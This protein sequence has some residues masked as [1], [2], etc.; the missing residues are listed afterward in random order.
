MALHTS[1]APLGIISTMSV[2]IVTDSGS[3][4]T[5]EL[6]ASL[7]VTVVPLRVLLGGKEYRDGVDLTPDAFY[8]KLR[9]VKELPKTSQPTPHDLEAAYRAAAQRGP[10]VG[11]HLSSALS[12]T[13]QGAAM[14]VRS[15]DP[16][17][18]LVDSRSGSGGE[19]LLVLEAV[20]LSR[21]GAGPDEIVERV[22]RMRLK[23]ETLV[24]LNT[25]ENAV[26]GG[27]VSPIA[28][29]AATLLGI[30][31]IV[32]VTDDGRV[33]PLD[34]VRGRGRALQRLLDLAAERRTDWRD[35]RVCVAHGG[36]EPDAR[37]FADQVRERFDPREVTILPIGATIGTYSAEGAILFSF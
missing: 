3:D 8:R 5:P 19:A 6:A 24:A 20:R 28:G 35:A 29:A 34:R 11:I 1:A 23:G 21:E 15:V 12:G 2:Q 32:H 30:K 13:F 25:L 22:E 36:A 4:I 18:R 26:R 9:E 14:A 7:G 10:V 27:R 37:A 16:S 33:E 17:I 31:P